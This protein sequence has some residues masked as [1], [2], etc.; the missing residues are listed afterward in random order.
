MGTAAPKRKMCLVL[1]GIAAYTFL[2]ITLMALTGPSGTERRRRLAPTKPGLPRQHRV[3]VDP[4]EP[5]RRYANTKKCERCYTNEPEV[6]LGKCEI[7]SAF[8]CGTCVLQLA[9]LPR[10]NNPRTCN[11]DSCKVEWERLNSRRL[12]ARHGPSII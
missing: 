11:S 4:T 3:Q 12:A 8:L 2:G 5:D 7:C 6:G 1:A 9:R 10:V